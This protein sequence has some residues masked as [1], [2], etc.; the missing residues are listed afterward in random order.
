MNAPK[1]TPGPWK[2][3]EDE[4]DG[5][6]VHAPTIERMTDCEYVVVSNVNGDRTATPKYGTPEA[7]ANLIAAAPDGYAAGESL[8]GVVL[9][10]IERGD[11]RVDGTCDPDIAI[12]RMQRFLTQARGEVA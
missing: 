3:R 10:A 5:L 12:S 4:F 7:N 11:W 1:F 6:C 8:L 9:A 2:V